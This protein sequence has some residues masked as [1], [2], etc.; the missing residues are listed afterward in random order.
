[1]YTTYQF[2][3]SKNKI[4]NIHR[5]CLSASQNLTNRTLIEEN[6]VNSLVKGDLEPPTKLKHFALFAFFEL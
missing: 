4:V 6:K 5:K 1:M 2:L 3:Y